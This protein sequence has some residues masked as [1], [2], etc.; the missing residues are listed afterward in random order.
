MKAPYT[1]YDWLIKNW[2]VHYV[3]RTFNQDMSPEILYDGY[4]MSLVELGYTVYGN[5]YDGV[6]VEVK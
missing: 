3:E 4:V 5:C 2:G 6:T 1:F